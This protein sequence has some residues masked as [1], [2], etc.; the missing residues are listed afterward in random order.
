MSTP[1]RGYEFTQ[2]QNL[3]IGAL[4]ARMRGVGFFLVFIAVLNF[5][6]AAG[7][8]TAIY[9]ARLPQSY[10]DSVLAKASD[11]TKTDVKAQLDKLPPDN[12][13][14]GIAIS[15]AVNGLIYLLIGVWTQSAAGSFQKIVDTQGSDI[16]HLMNA[17]SALNK[18]YSLIYTLIMIGLLCLLAMIGLF[19]YVHFTR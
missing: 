3:V 10:V 6:V 4:S 5:L 19:L 9:R 8:V 12:Q 14:W 18:M 15:S 11:A 13:L 2:D 1:P 16:N 7:I 17:L